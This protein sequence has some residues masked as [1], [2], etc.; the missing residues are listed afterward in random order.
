MTSINYMEAMISHGLANNC[1]D[2]DQPNVMHLT[3][4]AWQ[5]ARMGMVV[6]LKE[7]DMMLV[8]GS[9]L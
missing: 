4:D 8:V 2:I 3:F 6:H 5:K 1:E 9:P 7:V